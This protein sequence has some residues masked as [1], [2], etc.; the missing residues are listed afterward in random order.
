MDT[1]KHIGLKKNIW[2]DER[3][4]GINP[5][6]ALGIKAGLP[7]NL[8]IVSLKPGTVRG[9]HYHATATEWMLVFGGK[10]KIVWKVKKASSVHQIFVDDSEPALFEIPP[11]IEHAVI[12]DSTSDIYLAVFYDSHQPDTVR[13]PSLFNLHNEKT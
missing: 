5:L 9:D 1:V 12:N 8:H 11:D 4:W 7:G 2:K 13:C 6:E 3:G 10:A